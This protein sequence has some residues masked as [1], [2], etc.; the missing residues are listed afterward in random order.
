MAPSVF[1]YTLLLVR[2]N[3]IEIKNLGS[4]ITLRDCDPFH[5]SIMQKIKTK[6]VTQLSVG[7]EQVA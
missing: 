7:I 3:A 4:G 2:R 1:G 5:S 6:Q